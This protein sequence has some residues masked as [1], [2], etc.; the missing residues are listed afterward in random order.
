MDCSVRSSGQEAIERVEN[1]LAS[2]LYV[3]PESL[4]S[5]TIERLLIKRVIARFVIDRRTAFP[6]WGQ[7]FRVDYLYIGDFIRELQERRSS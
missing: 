2:I 1:G 3:A 5:K 4:R 7:D 6:A